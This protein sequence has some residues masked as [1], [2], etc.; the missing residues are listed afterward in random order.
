MERS[1][2]LEYINKVEEELLLQNRIRFGFDLV[3]LKQIASY[4]G[5]YILFDSDNLCYVGESSNLRERMSDMRHTYKHTIRKKIGKF[6]FDGK[7][8]KGERKFCPQVEERLNKFFSEKISVAHVP[9]DF[10]RTE[11]EEYLVDKYEGSIYNNKS[12]RYVKPF[13]K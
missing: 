2:V 13:N 9:I 10:G 7:I 4:P 11:I 12:N 1:K 3:F 5:V 6:H 8:K